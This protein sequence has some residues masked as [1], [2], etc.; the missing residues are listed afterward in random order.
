MTNY[1]AIKWTGD[2][3]DEFEAVGLKTFLLDSTRLNVYTFVLEI[4]D[5]VFRVLPRGNWRFISESELN[6]IRDD[7]VNEMRGKLGMKR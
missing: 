4:G 7:E 2:N 1:Q 3:K 6:A 5:G